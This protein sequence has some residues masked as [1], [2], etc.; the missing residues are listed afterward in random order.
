MR[1]NFRYTPATFIWNTTID[2]DFDFDLVLIR[3]L[4]RKGYSFR[5]S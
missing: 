4:P 2:E 3:G 5:L 1:P